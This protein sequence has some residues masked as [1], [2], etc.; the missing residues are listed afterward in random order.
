MPL[1]TVELNRLADSMVD[2]SMTVYLHTA[3]PT[4]ASPN[5]AR[6]SAGGG[7]F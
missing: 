4:D 5:N 6:L 3:A 7:R 1:F 2:A